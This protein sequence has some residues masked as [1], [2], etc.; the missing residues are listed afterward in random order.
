MK[1]N[2]IIESL[3]TLFAELV[4]GVPAGGGA[5]ILN[6]GDAGLLKSLDKVSVHE[7]SRSVNGGAT[8]AAHA[9]HLR[10]TR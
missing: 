4:N 5:Y 3:T 7:A 8:I 10:R 2:D 1:T 6:S 9:Q